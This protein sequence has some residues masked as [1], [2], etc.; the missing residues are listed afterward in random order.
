MIYFSL[1]RLRSALVSSFCAR[2]THT[3]A[4]CRYTVRSVS[5]SAV[6]AH[7][8]Q[9]AAKRQNSFDVLIASR[10][11]LNIKAQSA[12]VILLHEDQRQS[13]ICI[14]GITIR[15]AN[16]AKQEPPLLGGSAGHAVKSPLIGTS[17][18]GSPMARRLLAGR[19]MVPKTSPAARASTLHRADR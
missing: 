12:D 6:R 13:L 3:R 2:A 8:T 1:S 15:V 14:N 18:G 11:N 9:S 4:I 7:F 17:S 10:P 5:S 19:I 16:C